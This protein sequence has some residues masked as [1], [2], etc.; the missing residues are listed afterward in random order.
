MTNCTLMEKGCKKS[1]NSTFIKLD[2][3]VFSVDAY[4]SNIDGYSVDLCY[5]CTIA[6]VG[7]TPIIF[8]KD[9]IHFEQGKSF[10][11]SLMLD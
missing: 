3:T 7:L 1:F 4:S 8:Y 11:T 6:P 10:N 9:E 5:N 2:S